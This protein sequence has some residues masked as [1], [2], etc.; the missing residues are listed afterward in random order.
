MTSE[1]GPADRDEV[2]RFEQVNIAAED[3]RPILTDVSW[4]VGSGER[5]VVLGPN[6]AGKSTMLHIAS[7]YR[8]PTH[9]HVWVLGHQLGRV[10]L[11][12]LRRDIGYT[13]A[14]LERMMDERM[15]VLTT[16]LTGS[17]AHLSRWRETYGERE[18]AQ[19]QALI[20][21]MGIGALQE[22][23]LGT[24]SQGERRRA[25][26]ARALMA[27]P[28][29][30]L[31]D[32]P[33]AGLDVGGREHLVAVLGDLA[34]GPLEAIVFVTHHAEEIPPG[35]THALLL[36]DGGV[37]AAGPIEQVLTGETLSASFGLPLE[38]EHADGR[39]FAR[40]VRRVAGVAAPL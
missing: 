14:E 9:G 33:A 30:L 18:Q 38:V 34:A 20:R 3:R 7:T 4:R 2:L 22:R 16:V 5:W 10:D 31:L 28:R 15:S 37:V 29:L 40:A 26:I 6:G 1:Q 17:R 11:R 8:F 32:E 36:R 23:V 19:A 24:L 25:Q 12:E 21:D 35:F 27:Q 13:S 39:F